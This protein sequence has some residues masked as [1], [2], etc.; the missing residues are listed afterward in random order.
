MGYTPAFLRRALCAAAFF[1]AVGLPLGATTVDARPPGLLVDRV[2]A[3][4][5]ADQAG[6]VVRDVITAVEGAPLTKIE[7]IMVALARHKPGDRMTISIR[8][9]AS[10]DV[11]NVSLRLGASPADATKPYMGLSVLAVYV[12]VPEGALPAAPSPEA[13]TT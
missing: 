1:A 7:D 8:R 12:L 9:A 2:E 4:G 3:N 13:P 5:P 11:V 6:I 10:G